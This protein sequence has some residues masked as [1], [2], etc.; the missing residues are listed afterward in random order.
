MPADERA[1]RCSIRKLKTLTAE[2]G[3]EPVRM[4]RPARRL[5]DA[6]EPIA[7]HNA[8][9]T[10]T[11]ERAGAPGLDRF[12]A[13]V[14]GRAAPMGEPTAAVVVAAFG[15][16]E[17]ALLAAAYERGRSAVGREA[18]LKARV[19]ATAVSLRGVLGDIDVYLR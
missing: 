5:R 17:P 9:Y 1:F 6:F 2:R 15:V 11:L 7:M 4:A 3:P 12:A 8:G 18:L 14:W 16:F 13:Y 19:D 10:A